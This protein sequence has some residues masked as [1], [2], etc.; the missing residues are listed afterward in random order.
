MN[1]LYLTVNKVLLSLYKPVIKLALT[2]SLLKTRLYGVLHHKQ[3][4]SKK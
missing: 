4:I 1:N 3:L 2:Q